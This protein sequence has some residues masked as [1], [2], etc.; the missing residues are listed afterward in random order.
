MNAEAPFQRKVWEGFT[1]V[2]SVL[3][4]LA[5]VAVWG[6]AGPAYPQEESPNRLS[7]PFG[8]A[9]ANHDG[10]NDLF[11]DADG[12]GIDDV[13]GKVYLHVFPY[14]DSD[15]DGKNDYWQDADG[16][17]KNDLYLPGKRI[18]NYFLVLA[19]DG[20]DDGLNDV[21]GKRIPGYKMALPFRKAADSIADRK[22]TGTGDESKAG[23][24]QSIPQCYAPPAPPPAAGK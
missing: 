2:R 1:M 18:G 7:A 4:A 21:T 20:D 6:L 19:L 24:D 23:Q 15:H 9:D 16:D 14:C 13:T 3:V 11:R 5:A 12:D 8:F 10:I 22:K 17:G